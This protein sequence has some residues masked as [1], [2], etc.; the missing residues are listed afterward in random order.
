MHT[1]QFRD[2]AAKPVHLH[3]NQMMLGNQTYQLDT[4]IEGQK[5]RLSL[6][7]IHRYLR[8]SA[9]VYG[10][11]FHIPAAAVIFDL[12]H[13]LDVLGHFLPLITQL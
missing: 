8:E 4:I 1:L 5:W 3:E 6:S 9:Y 7:A 13:E 11:P 10:E 2:I 12:N